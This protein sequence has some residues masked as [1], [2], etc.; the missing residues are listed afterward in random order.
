M[1]KHVKS[2]RIVEYG[3]GSGFVLEM[4]SA[5]FPGSMILGVDESLDCLVEVRKKNLRNVIPVQADMTRTAF[6][7]GVMDTVLFVASLH[8]AYSYLGRERVEDAFK[9]AYDVLREDGILIIQDFLKPSP[10]LVEI[11]PRNEQTL[12]KLL[13][14]G[15]EFRPREVHHQRERYGFLLDIADAVEFISKYRSPT[16]EDWN[17]EMTETHFFFTEEEYQKV[18]QN[19]GFTVRKS[20]RLVHS[21]RWW[22]ATK[23]DI[24]FQ[25]EPRY[26]WI[27]LVLKKKE[28]ALRSTSPHVTGAA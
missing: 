27:Q 15:E 2:G 7:E 13:R 5:G 25:F 12:E 9:I 1:S 23:E 21:E 8:V 19:A 10:E 16:E 11:A 18:A 24:E 4:L 14:F 17:E 6:G 28:S 20:D 3:C 22:N 26:S